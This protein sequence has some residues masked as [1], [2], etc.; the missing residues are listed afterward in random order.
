MERG[1]THSYRV[2][3]AVAKLGRLMRVQLCLTS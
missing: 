2:D 1:R 3:A